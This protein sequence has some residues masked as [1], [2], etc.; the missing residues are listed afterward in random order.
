MLGKYAKTNL[1][2]AASGF[3]VFEADYWEDFQN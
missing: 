3:R 1:S 2:E